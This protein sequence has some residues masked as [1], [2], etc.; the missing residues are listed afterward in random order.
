MHRFGTMVE[1]PLVKDDHALVQIEASL[2]R[3]LHFGI[4]GPCVNPIQLS[5]PGIYVAAICRAYRTL[6][7][8]DQRYIIDRCVCVIH[9]VECR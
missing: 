4:A 1:L 7:V 9:V 3:F 2:D 5:G 8:V 6:A